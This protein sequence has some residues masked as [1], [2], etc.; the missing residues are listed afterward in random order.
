M[1]VMKNNKTVLSIGGGE[2]TGRWKVH[3]SEVYISSPPFSAFMNLF[4]VCGVGGGEREKHMYEERE[5]E[6]ERERTR[7]KEERV[8]CPLAKSFAPPLLE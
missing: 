3:S 4:C 6:R 1:T 7:E 2:A 5:R 8:I